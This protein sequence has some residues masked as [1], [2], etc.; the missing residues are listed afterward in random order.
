MDIFNL[1]PFDDRT[2]F[3]YLTL[4]YND[5]VTFNKQMVEDLAMIELSNIAERGLTPDKDLISNKI[6]EID[7]GTLT[8][9]ENELNKCETIIK[10]EL[11]LRSIFTLPENKINELVSSY[12]FKNN[13]QNFFSVKNNVK[14]MDSIKNTPEFIPTGYKSIDN[15]FR[16]GITPDAKFIILAAQ[17][18]SGKTAV[19]LNLADSYARQDKKVLFISFEESE[20]TLL[21]RYT[22]KHLHISLFDAP[23]INDYQASQVL[24]SKFAENVALV[25]ASPYSLNVDDFISQLENN[26]EHFD[27]VMIDYYTKFWKNPK[28]DPYKEE[29]YISN[30]LSDYANRANI[31]IWSAAQKTKDSWDKKKAPSIADIGNSRTSSEV[32]ST[33]IDLSIGETIDSDSYVLKLTILKDRQA[34]SRETF[35]MKFVKTYQSLEEFDE[36][37]IE[38]KKEEKQIRKITWKD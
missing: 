14:F 2:E 9:S 37:P 31:L 5:R 7:N 35:N 3:A 36:A 34:A 32:A 16:G 28:S 1:I 27:V 4:L 18:N 38:Q 13:K 12:N 11:A 22:Q 15:A 21:T 30:K 26:E 29:E 25:Y 24:S 20:K 10:R 8:V 17:T 23:K 33:I 6:L 19:M